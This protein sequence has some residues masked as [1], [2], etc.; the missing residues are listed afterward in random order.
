MSAEQQAKFMRVIAV[1]THVALGDNIDFPRVVVL[2]AENSGKSSTLEMLSGIPFPI[3][4]ELT[5]TCAIVVSKKIRLK[6]ELP[7]GRPYYDIY[8][9]SERNMRFPPG[10]G[11]PRRCCSNNGRRFRESAEVVHVLGGGCGTHGKKR[12]SP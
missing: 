12:V 2:G 8:L 3:N 10:S 5:T 1:L 7:G 11:R 6:S 9:K 4:D